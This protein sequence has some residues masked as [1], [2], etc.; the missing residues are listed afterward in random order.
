MRVELITCLRV[1][2]AKHDILIKKE[3][4]ISYLAKKSLKKKGG[5]KTSLVEGE[6]QLYLVI[7]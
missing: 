1:I 6:Y 4:G 3:D 2:L 7:C 5:F